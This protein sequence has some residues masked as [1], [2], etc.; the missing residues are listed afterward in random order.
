MFA[1]WFPK[2]PQI[3]GEKQISSGDLNQEGNLNQE[4]KR[5]DSNTEDQKKSLNRL[6]S[7][8]TTVLGWYLVP[9]IA[10]YISISKRSYHRTICCC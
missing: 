4:G 1:V 6:K 8:K 5:A 3:K 7:S 2:L 10:L 9:K